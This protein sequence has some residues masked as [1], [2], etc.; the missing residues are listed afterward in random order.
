MANNNINRSLTGTSPLAYMGINASG[1]YSASQT[2]VHY[3][4]PTI[5]DSKNFIIGCLWL[6]P[7]TDS[8]AHS[9][10]IWMLTALLGNDATWTELVASGA[11][12][13]LT[14]TGD[15]GGA[16]GPL[17]G[18]VNLVAG[19]G[20]GLSVVG[21]P[22]TY[23]LTIAGTGGGSVINQI[24][25]DTGYV[26][27]PTVSIK[28]NATAG[29]TVEFIGD[30][31]TAMTFNVTDADNNT[32]VGSNSG[33]GTLSGFTNT[34]LGRSAL[35]GLTTG[36]FNTSLG[37]ISGSSLTTGDSNV[38]VGFSAG[39]QLTTGNTNIAVGN[40]AAFSYI[41]AESSN[42]CIG[43]QG[44]LGESNTLRIGTN[45]STS[46]RQNRCFIAGIDGVD[47]GSVATVVTENANQ[48]GTAVITA[49]SG[50]TVTPSAN[51]ITIATTGGGFGDTAFNAYIPA[52]DEE[53]LTTAGVADT[54]Y[55]GTNSAGGLPLTEIFDPGNNFYPGDG[56]SAAATYTVPS[57]GIYAFTI[58]G[59][60]SLSVGTGDVIIE[61]NGSTYAQILGFATG[62]QTPGYAYSAPYLASLSAG[63]VVKFALFIYAAGQTGKFSSVLADGVCGV[64]G[65]RVA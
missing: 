19:A 37:G 3:R 10:Q 5:N 6:W 14:I 40:L 65:Y 53:S 31:A 9:A 27:G 18:N 42:I 20:S 46:G 43:H 36:S 38:F 28:G 62:S 32:L 1:S 47:V 45:G 54:L 59:F 22:G 15:S 51:A 26:T 56:V 55:M 29:S 12:G 57:T 61:V 16:V 44:V 23:T 41:G 33:N 58:Y 34:G 63:D 49:G 39:D 52:N 4:A 11:N 24:D 48:L 13:I 21:N 30:N 60:I 8:P 64:F 17:L 7:D 35:H 50:I 25:G 2:V